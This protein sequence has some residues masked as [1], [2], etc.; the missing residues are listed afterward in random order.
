[1]KGFNNS[2]TAVSKRNPKS[3][4]KNRWSTQ[5]CPGYAAFMRTLP[6]IGEMTRAYQRSDASYDGIFFL[7]VRTTGVF[8]KP[9]C[10]ARKPLAKNVLFFASVREALFAGFRP[11]K[12]CRPLNDAAEAP[13]WVEQLLAQIDAD[14]AQRLGDADLRQR[15]IQPARARRYFRKHFGITFQAYARA[16]RMSKA[17]AQIRNRAKID[18]VVLGNGFQSHSGFRDA[19]AKTFG[20]TP[21]KSSATDCIL[22]DWF[23]SP[24][25]PLIA[26]AT[27]DGICLLEFTER[28][29]LEAQFET[30]RKRFQC[31]V[32]PGTNEHLRL[33]KKELTSYFAGTLQQFS[34]P[35]IYPGSAFQK[36]VWDE[37]RRI[38]YGQTCS[39]EEL[40]RR[41]GSPG[42]Q[43]AVGRANGL[44]RIAIVIPCHRVVNKDGKLGGYGGGLWR[45][46]FLLDLEER[47]AEC[48]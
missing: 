28:R 26:G 44:N 35:L 18:D 47:N 45:K 2:K 22:L 40:A 6:T 39:Y 16:R 13:R 25:G 9:S 7:G 46:Q 38:P 24:L 4:L 33:L 41:A 36:R 42:A 15:G 10:Q 37:L 23:E 20:T 30:L 32:V 17:L 1:M 27:A 29:M 19:F 48:K 5:G 34:V 8:C 31:A 43:R 11:C 14:P 21:G 12:R 3:A